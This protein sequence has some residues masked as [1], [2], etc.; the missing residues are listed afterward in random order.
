MAFLI[1]SAKRKYRSHL[2]LEQEYDRQYNNNWF[3]RRCLHNSRTFSTVNQ[4]LENQIH[5]R[6]LNRNVCVI[7]WRRI[8][9]VYLR[10]LHWEYS[11]YDCEFFSFH[12]SYPNFNAQGEV[13]VR[14][15]NK[16]ASDKLSVLN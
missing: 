4:G 13:Q 1:Y 14:R 9:M 3:N 16:G 15:F 2:N 8:L 10:S 6:H 11:D 5:Q 7:L 12:S